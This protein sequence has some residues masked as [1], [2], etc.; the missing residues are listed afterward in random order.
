[1][2]I[3]RVDLNMITSLWDEKWGWRLLMLEDLI[4][5]DFIESSHLV[6]LDTLG[7]IFTWNNNRGKEKQIASRL[8]LFLISKNII[9][10]GG[11]LIASILPIDGLDH[12]PFYLTWKWIGVHVHWPFKFEKF[13]DSQPNFQ[14]MVQTWWRNTSL[15]ILQD[16]H[17][18]KKVELAHI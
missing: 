10:T 1:M 13:W 15:G 4:F 12:S 14:E 8:Y 6:D 3:I 2:C 17:H 7:G 9:R 5:K 11:D 18:A 16:G